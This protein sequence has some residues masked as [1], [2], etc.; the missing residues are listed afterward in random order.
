MLSWL[1]GCILIHDEKNVDIYWKKKSGKN[2]E[3]KG[4]KETREMFKSI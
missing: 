1:L 3:S 2:L 4:Q